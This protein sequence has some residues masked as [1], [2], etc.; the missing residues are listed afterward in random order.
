MTFWGARG[1]IH[2]DELEK[3]KRITGDNYYSL[4]RLS[5][6]IKKHAPHLNNKNILLHQENAHLR[7]F[8]GQ[9]CAIKLRI[10]KLIKVKY[11]KI[12]KN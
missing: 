8:K 11:N 4:L 6:A 1:I 12:I 7:G 5:E 2:I 3:R 9:N 10:V